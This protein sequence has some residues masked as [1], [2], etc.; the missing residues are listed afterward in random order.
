MSVLLAGAVI[1]ASAYGIAGLPHALL[2]IE[3]GYVILATLIVG[4]IVG[5]LCDKLVFRPQ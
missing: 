3:A 4:A 5:G 1:A 2:A